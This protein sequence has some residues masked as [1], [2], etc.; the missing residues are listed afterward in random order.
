MGIQHYT[1]VEIGLKS[2]DLGILE[3]D[4]WCKRQR[5]G[6]LWYSVTGTSKHQSQVTG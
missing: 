6:S 5:N 2:W 4:T 1:L 3:Q